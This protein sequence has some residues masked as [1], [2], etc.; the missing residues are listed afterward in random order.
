MC[1]DEGGWLVDGR[2]HEV[3]TTKG[4]SN[5]LHCAKPTAERVSGHCQTERAEQDHDVVISSGCTYTGLTIDDSYLQSATRIPEGEKDRVVLGRGAK[6]REGFW[7]TYD[8]GVYIADQGLPVSECE[9]IVQVD[10]GLV[11]TELQDEGKA[12]KKKEIPVTAPPNNNQ[13]QANTK[14]NKKSKKKISKDC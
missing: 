13:K 4:Y 10:S 11:G 7:R 1:F 5:D 6:H 3:R 2:V 12:S 9:S 8:E 14:Q